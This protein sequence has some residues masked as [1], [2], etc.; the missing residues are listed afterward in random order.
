MQRDHWP[1]R[2]NM[3]WVLFATAIQLPLLAAHG[4]P[5]AIENVK[6]CTPNNPFVT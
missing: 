5:I 2:M 6:L 4:F 3:Q 1:A